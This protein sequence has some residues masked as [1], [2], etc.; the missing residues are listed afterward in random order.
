MHIL[1]LLVVIA[2]VSSFHFA[3]AEVQIPFWVDEKIKF[4]A[5]DKISS[6]D[7]DTALSWLADK[8]QIA[9][10][11]YEKQKISPSFKNY[12][13]SWMNGKIS[14]SEFFGKV[15][16]E[17]QSGSIQLT[18]SGYDKKSYKEH[19]YSGYSPLFR[20]FAYK[21][22]FVMD[23]GI[24]APKAMQFEKRSNQTEAY[25]KI[26][27]DGKDAVVIRPIFTASAYYEPGFYTFYRNEC[28]SKCLT[29][30]I[31]YGQPYG[32]SG[33]SNSMKV[34]R[35][36]GYKEITDIDVDKNPEI[37]SKYKKVIVLHN[38]YV[39]Q[40]EF[41]AI[42]KH[43]HVLYLYPNA[44]YAKISVNYQNDSISLIRGH[45]YPTKE[46]LNGFDWKFDNSKLEYDKTCANWKFTKIKNGKMLSCYPQNIIFSD[47]R[48]LKEIKDY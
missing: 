15:Y 35:L 18:K 3:T 40:K 31:K 5:N 38:E 26:S 27:S 48:L 29:T 42:T 28:D 19:E 10:K 45:H 33:S 17:L 23:N 44:L 14:D 21:K 8:N 7:L 32:Y 36:L 1:F 46:I 34:L 25:Q 9:I 11:S 22:D 30:T 16:A 4:W 6:T 24:R 41:D 2:F 12:T 47:Y 13:K 39:T 20:V 43:P 37:L